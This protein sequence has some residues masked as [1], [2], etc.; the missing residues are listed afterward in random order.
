M[1][2]ASMRIFVLNK[3]QVLEENLKKGK[4]QWDDETER[5][6][7]DITKDKVGIY[8][9]RK[10]IA[11]FGTIS[12]EGKFIDLLIEVLK[13]YQLGL[14]Y[15]TIALCGMAIE[16]L[17]YDFI[18]FSKI[19]VNNTELDQVAKHELYNIPLRSL[20]EFLNK[21]GIIDDGSKNLL[22]KINDRRNSHVHPKMIRN[23]QDDALE[24]INLLCK[25]IENIFSRVVFMT[26]SYGSIS[27]RRI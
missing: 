15:S 20:I 19:L 18:D 3:K 2:T 8:E 25:A 1:A 14:Y 22:F 9:R 23:A 24:V 26:D 7:Y 16:R 12:A 13:S 17:C 6:I 21:V 11:G 4:N 5:L 27:F 10:V